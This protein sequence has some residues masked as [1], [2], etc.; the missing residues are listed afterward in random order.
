MES[1]SSILILLLLF[2]IIVIIIPTLLTFANID[3]THYY[4]PFQ[5]FAIGMFILYFMLPNRSTKLY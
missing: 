3:V 4:T 5:I 2:V 1:F